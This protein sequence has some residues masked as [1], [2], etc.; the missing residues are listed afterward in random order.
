[1]FIDVGFC[2]F[3]LFFECGLILVDSS[4]LLVKI[5]KVCNLVLNLMVGDDFLI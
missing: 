2:V 5:V 3:L 1:M 4:A